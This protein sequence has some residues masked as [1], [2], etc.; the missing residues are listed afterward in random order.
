MQFIIVV[1]MPPFA[2]YLFGLQLASLLSYVLQP[3]LTQPLE[4]LFPETTLL[5]T[6]KLTSPFKGE[7]LGLSILIANCLN[8]LIDKVN[9]I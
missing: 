7:R 6:I 1:N 2:V 8:E 4:H 9:D 5:S 3:M